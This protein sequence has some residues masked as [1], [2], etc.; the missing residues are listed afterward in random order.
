MTI[1]ASIVTYNTDR[2]E[3]MKCIDSLRMN[4]VAPVYISDNSPVDGLRG[5]CKDLKGVNY[6]FN[7]KNLGYGAGHN[8]AIRKAQEYGSTYHL[9][10]NSDVYFGKGV[11][12]AIVGYMDANADVGQLIPNVVY[13]D[14]RIQ[15]VVRLLPTPVDLIFR[16]F[17]P[18]WIVKRRNY[19]YCLE[20]ADHSR[21]MNVAY[22]QGSFLFFRM[23]SLK[24]VGLFD[25]RFFMY[26]EDIDIT[27]RM[28]RHYRTM[29]WPGA[30]IVHAHRAASYKNMRMLW[31][32]IVNMVR[33]FNK[34]GWFF[35]RE[36][37]RWNR[38]L[39]EETGYKKK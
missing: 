18:N 20:F 37:R 29:F 30:T 32:H 9:V 28:H 27:R 11:I 10:I 15:Y 26:P 7:G 24:E 23:S 31:V 4:G 36:R 17:L 6:I 38:H 5:F 25:E 21:P 2:G 34:W 22:H 13:P 39:L 33:Y 16:R 14:G 1:S 3:L 35:D 12:P 8:V 19:R